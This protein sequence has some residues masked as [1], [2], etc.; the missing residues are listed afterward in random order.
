MISP[1]YRAQVEL[2]I[3]VL[4]H[5]AK[6]HSL[7]LKGGTA[8]NLFVRDMPRLSVDID[9]TYLPVGP[10]AE[11]L[12]GISEALDRIKVGLEKEVLG[13]SVT[14]PLQDGGQEAK[15]ICTFRQATV[16]VEVNTVIRGCLWPTRRMPLVAAVQDE[17]GLFA[18]SQIVSQAELFGG[19]ICAGLDR[20]HPR[21]LFDIHQLFLDE[22]I[23]REIKDGFLASLVSHSRPMNELLNPNFLD[24]RVVFDTQ[25]IG[26]TVAPFT[27]L[28]LEAA[29][30]RLVND[31]HESLSKEDRDFLLSFKSGDPDWSLFPHEHLKS[32]PAVQWKLVN[33][34]K[35][36]TENT[37]KHAEQ[38]QALRA[39]LAR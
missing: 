12:Q 26:M 13:I 37:T 22:G 18:T 6:V 21:D 8:I 29:R 28:E 2:L 7:A 36:K 10:R 33:I 15:L 14:K 4:P 34:R 17:F 35:L 39:V 3:R 32:L 30:K 1:M 24:Q 27:Y 31:V 19:K 9:L 16:K 38:F 23:T 5:I 11:S 20:Q 25:F